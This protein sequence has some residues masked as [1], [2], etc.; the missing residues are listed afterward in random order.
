MARYDECLKTLVHFHDYL[1]VVRKDLRE[2][3]DQKHSPFT[4]RHNQDGATVW[5]IQAQFPKRQRTFQ[6]GLAY[7]EQGFPVLG[8]YDFSQLA[9]E[10]EDRA[11]FVDVGGGMGSA[12]AAI[13]EA[14]PQLQPSQMVLEDL[15]PVLEH[16]KAGKT[17]PDGV[18]VIPHDFWT[19]QPVQGAKAYYVRRIM[20]DYSDEHCVEILKHIRNAMAAD[21]RVLISEMLL[22]KKV[23]EAGLSATMM[24]NFMMSMGGKER[25]EEQFR[26]LLLDAGLELVKVWTL[27]DGPPG[28]GVVEG[29][30]M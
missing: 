28:V 16:V 18:K 5:D 25:T 8:M 14:C 9:S 10:N 11:A 17:V 4:A 30:K 13:L 3:D 7:A 6:L 29:R 15:P 19:P 21:S 26:Q 20:H 24:D 22:P 1:T 23:D 12:I 2:P 27:K